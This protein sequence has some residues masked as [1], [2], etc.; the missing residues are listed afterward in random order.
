MRNAKIFWEF[1]KQSMKISIQQ[2]VGAFFFVIGKLLRFGMFGMFV[3]FLL[4]GTN[5]LAG[6]NLQQTLIFFLTFNIVD[7]ITQL[8]FRQVYRFRPLILSGDFDLILVKP[9][10]PFLRVLVGGVDVL[11]SIPLSIFTGLLVW[12]LSTMDGITTGGIVLYLLLI[13]NALL[14][15]T[16]FHILVLAMGIVSTEVDH[17]IMIYRDISR[18]GSFPIDIYTQPLRGFLTFVIPIGVMISFPV[19]ALIGLLQPSFILVSFVIGI[20]FLSISL[21]CWRKALLMYQSASS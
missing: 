1:T 8:L 2:P 4:A 7:G 3:Y 12:L 14:I 16:G 15:A 13:G 21:W 5:V 17:T 20:A 19:Q 10:N 11:D 9:M 18:M 6:Y